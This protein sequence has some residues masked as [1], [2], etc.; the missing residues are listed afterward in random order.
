MSW[1]VLS[2]WYISLSLLWASITPGTQT[3][4]IYAQFSFISKVLA[5]ASIHYSQEEI[6]QLVWG[7]FCAGLIVGS[8]LLFVS[9]NSIS[10]WLQLVLFFVG[11][12][13]ILRSDVLGQE[14]VKEREWILHIGLLP[15]G[16]LC[17]GLIVSKQRETFNAVRMLSL[18]CLLQAI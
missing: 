10:I 18:A 8:S 14:I 6:I 11:K 12:G 13:D 17:F 4:P 5:L 1:Y 7:R 2:C 3:T 16:I 9:S 15:K